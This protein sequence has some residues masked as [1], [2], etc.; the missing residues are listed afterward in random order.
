[1]IATAEITNAGVD[2]YP[3]TFSLEITDDSAGGG[4]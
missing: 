4:R 2:E 1:M 3:A